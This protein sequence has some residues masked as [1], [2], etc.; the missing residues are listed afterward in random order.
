[1]PVITDLLTILYTIY[2]VLSTVQ[3]DNQGMIVSFVKKVNHPCSD[4]GCT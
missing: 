4:R 3:N 2:T 1:M